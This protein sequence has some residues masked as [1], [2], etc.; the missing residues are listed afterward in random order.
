MHFTALLVAALAGSA[1]GH[2][3]IV[4]PAPL[5]SKENPNSRNAVDYDINS[6]L[7]DMSQFPCKGALKYLGQPEGASVETYAPGGTY[8]MVIGTG[9]AHNGGSCQISLSYDKGKTFTVIKSII[10]N[11]PAP[12]ASYKFTVPAD[13]P[14]GEAVFSWS[15]NNK[16][17]NREFYQN[18]AV[19]TIAGGS[20][21]RSE[22]LVSRDVAFSARPQIF[23]SNLGGEF[24]TPENI[25]VVYP[26]PGP[27]VDRNTNSPGN[28]KICASGAEVPAGGSGGGGSGG[29]SGGSAPA[30]TSAAAPPASPTSAPAQSSAPAGPTSA[31]AQP[32]P[33]PS[34]V[35]PPGGVFVTVP[36]SASTAPAPTSSATTLKTQTSA[37]ASSPVASVTPTPTSVTPPPAVT[38]GGAAAPAPSSAP[39]AGGAGG[40]LTGAC[41]NEGAWNC[42]GGTSFQRCASGAWSAT[43]QMAAG[44]TCKAGVSATLVT[45]RGDLGALRRRRVG[46]WN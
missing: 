10:G 31:P 36:P 37:V 16:S 22:N 34:A 41:T 9:A 30:P 35:L 28:A 4:K 19:V 7:S 27:D 18:C 25:D 42:I 40:S 20:Q 3:A 44:T 13:A 1:V 6:P 46:V 15:W 26:N 45:R 38:S 21:K 33:Q 43:I 2:I 23:V 24:C 5:R 8:D 17:G 12:G 14:K 29:G 32:A 11:C 39:P